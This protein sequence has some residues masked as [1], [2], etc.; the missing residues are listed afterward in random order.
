M[1]SHLNPFEGQGPDAFFYMGEKGSDITYADSVGIL[2]P[3]P[4]NDSAP[5]GEY[6]GVKL[7]LKMPKGY[8]TCNMAWLSVWC[9]KFAVDFGHV[10]VK[11]VRGPCPAYKL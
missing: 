1:L 4:E 11:E 3:Y 6:N 5:L 8:K 9:R 2:I 7:T 10:K